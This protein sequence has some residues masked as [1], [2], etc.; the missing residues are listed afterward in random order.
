MGAALIA[1]CLL[2]VDVNSSPSAAPAISVFSIANP[3]LNSDDLSLRNSGYSTRCAGYVARAQYEAG[4]T[5]CNRA[6]EVYEA[7]WRARQSSAI[8]FARGQTAVA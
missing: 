2:A 7:N 6:L 1:G 3:R 4:L 5:Y 8:K